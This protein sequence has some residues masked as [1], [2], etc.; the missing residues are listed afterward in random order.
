MKYIYS[1]IKVCGSLFFTLTVVF[2]IQNIIHTYIMLPRVELVSQLHF[3]LFT[4]ITS[5]NS[6]VS[7]LETANV[8]LSENLLK[9]DSFA[10]QY[11]T[12]G[13]VTNSS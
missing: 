1:H 9:K 3:V 13:L 6:A 10:P 5:S 2:C 11:T 8:K 12:A 7:L 4:F